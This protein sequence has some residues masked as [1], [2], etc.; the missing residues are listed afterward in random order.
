MK[1][2]LLLMMLIFSTFVFGNSEFEKSYGESI[3]NNLKFG[4]TKQEFE[5][6]I[7][8]KALPESH[9]EGNYAVY[10]YSNIKD[11]LGIERQLNSFNFVDGRLVSSIF[12]SQTTDAEH[13]Q[14]IKMYIKNQNKLSKEKMIKLEGKGKLLLYN[15]KKT[16]EIARILDHTFIAVQT[17][18]PGVLEYKIRAIKQN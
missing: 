12:D 16:I 1:K 6:V 3:T 10:Y 14:I 8:K 18:A 5:K 4:M 7:Q 13:D 11:P 15:S 17:A 2:I 9:D